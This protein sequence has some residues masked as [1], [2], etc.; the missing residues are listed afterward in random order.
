MADEK[1]FTM[2]VQGISNGHSSYESK[3]NGKFYH[4]GLLLVPGS[5]HNLKI[6]LGSTSPADFVPGSVIKMKVKPRFWNGKFA[7]LKEA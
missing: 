5:E 1:A 6:E 2:F 7:G 4:S 3:K